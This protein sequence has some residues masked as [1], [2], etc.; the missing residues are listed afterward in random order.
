MHRR[1]RRVI[2]ERA[3]SGLQ[4]AEAA[5]RPRD[6]Q[7]G[8]QEA[9]RRFARNLLAQRSL[10]P[11]ETMWNDVVSGEVLSLRKC[12]ISRD[13]FLA[14]RLRHVR[15]RTD[16]VGQRQL[17]RVADRNAQPAARRSG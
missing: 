17:Q 16:Q 3:L 5:V 2:D 11:A 14:H 13:G 7:R 4:Q 1:H 9:P 12:R 10:R 6:Q 15:L 8:E